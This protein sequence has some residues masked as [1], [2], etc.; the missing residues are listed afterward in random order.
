MRQYFLVVAV[1]QEAAVGISIRR[2]LPQ[3]MLRVNALD[4]LGRK[5]SNEAQRPL[6]DPG[7]HRAA[8]CR[9]DLHNR[10]LGGFR[11]PRDWRVRCVR[12][13]GGNR[14]RLGSQRVVPSTKRRASFVSVKSTS[15]AAAKIM[16]YWI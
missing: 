4:G 14:F 2:L 3:D 12:L 5:G 1:E 15:E 9:C 8:L 13:L 16:V 10:L 6:A 7:E 11:H